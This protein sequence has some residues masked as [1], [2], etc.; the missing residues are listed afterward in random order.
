MDTCPLSKSGIKRSS[1][2]IGTRANTLS[3]TASPGKEETSAVRV[4]EHSSTTNKDSPCQGLA[5]TE[6]DP[7]EGNN[8][9]TA[10]TSWPLSNV[11]KRPRTHVSLK[12]ALFS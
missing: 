4:L 7:E 6:D 3:T 1:D 12:I 9:Y 2:V 8:S 10:C 5:L 11:F